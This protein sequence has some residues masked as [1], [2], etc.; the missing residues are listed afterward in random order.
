MNYTPYIT[1]ILL[2]GVLVEASPENKSKQQLRCD[3]TVRYKEFPKKVDSLAEMLLDGRF[4]G[5]FRMNS[6]VYNNKDN[7]KDHEVV[8]MGGSLTYRSAYFNGFGLGASFYTSVTPWQNMSQEPLEF[9]KGGK[10]TI[11]RYD[12]STGKGEGLT[13]LAQAFIEYRGSDNR[14]KVGRQ[15]FESFL[16]KSNDT[17][18]IP[19]SFEGVSFE[20]RTFTS[21]TIKTALLTRQKLKDHSS[22]HHVL[23]YGD[24]PNDAYAKWSQNDDGAM[25]QGLTISKL[26]EQEIEDRLLILDVKNSAI[27]NVTLKANYTTVPDLLSS[28]MVEGSYRFVFEKTKL[29]PSVRYMTQFDNGAGAIGGANLKNN[30]VGYDDADSL[31]GNLFASRLDVIQRSW[32]LRFGYSSVADKGDIVAPW[33]GYP[34]AG[35]TRAMG[36]YNWNANTDTYLLRADYNLDKA[37]L[38]NG[39]RL[40]MR[41][42][43]QNFDDDKAGV[44]SDK[45]VFTIN[46]VK[47][48]F[49]F[50]PN[51]YAKIRVAFIDGKS[52]T[53]AVDGTLKPDSSYNEFRFEF[54]YLF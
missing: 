18:M 13:S 33:R 6:F 3:M 11:S 5:R 4:Y 54:N 45:K 36:Q 22:F 25:H 41:Y 19:N 47:R 52:D 35:Y 8:A 34:T 48:G 30:T 37:G 49:V 28:M 12:V 23:A 15:L 40:M 46:L 7:Q 10:D 1:L 24:D 29:I 32:S 53:V 26:N 50:S 21:T 51:L 27:T 31:D 14:V 39:G 2:S 9:Y 20:N 42:A 16:T 44:S 43:V 17:K 38:L